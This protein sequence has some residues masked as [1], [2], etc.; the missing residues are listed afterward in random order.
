[1]KKNVLVVPVMLV[2]AFLSFPK[3]SGVS[4]LLSEGV[5]VLTK[6]EG[7]DGYDLSSICYESKGSK[8]YHGEFVAYNCTKIKELA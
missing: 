2:S 7:N 6:C 8:C 1:M 5:E 3:S 4:S